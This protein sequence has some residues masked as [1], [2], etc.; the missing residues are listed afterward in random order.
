MAVWKGTPKKFKIGFVDKNPYAWD[1][2][3]DEVE[4]RWEYATSSDI[5]SIH[6]EHPQMREYKPELYS[7]D[8]AKAYIYT[9]ANWLAT[10]EDVGTLKELLK[11]ILEKKD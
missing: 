7:P 3:I 11:P 9:M 4:F 8:W 5:L 1:E 6:A 2:T 10:Y